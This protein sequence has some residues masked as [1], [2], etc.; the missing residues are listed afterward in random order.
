MRPADFCV[1]TVLPIPHGILES[2]KELATSTAACVQAIR[3]FPG[4]SLE[5]SQSTHA[6]KFTS[7]A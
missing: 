3:P 6:S 2:T 5:G 1:N 4:L 7:Q